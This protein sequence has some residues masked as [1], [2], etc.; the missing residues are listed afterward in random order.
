[1]GSHKKYGTTACGRPECG[2]DRIPK[3]AE[4]AQ[5]VHILS[6]ILS[7]D[8]DKSQELILSQEKHGFLPFHGISASLMVGA[9]VDV[10]DGNHSKCRN[11]FSLCRDAL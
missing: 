2:Q 5:Y 6:E 7:S 9:W 8:L 1:M 11:F 4:G 10:P 3:G